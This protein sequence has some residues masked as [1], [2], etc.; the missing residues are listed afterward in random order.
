[1][2]AQGI[3][4]PTNARP[5]LQISWVHEHFPPNAPHDS[6]A[7]PKLRTRRWKLAPRAVAHVLVDCLLAGTVSVTG[8]LRVGPCLPPGCFLCVW[9]LLAGTGV[10]RLGINP[11]WFP[12]FGS[13]PC[14]PYC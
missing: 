4:K 8:A 2:V 1:M 7:E 14:Y 12:E 9:C 3:F 10:P 6:N 13:V 11:G 5:H